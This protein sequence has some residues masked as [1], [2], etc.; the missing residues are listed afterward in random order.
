[1]FT[2]TAALPVA[3]MAIR[4]AKRP[5]DTKRTFGYHRFENPGGSLQRGALF[6]RRRVMTEAA[7]GL[8]ICRKTLWEKM[9]RHGVD[10]QQFGE[11]VEGSA[12]P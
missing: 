8:V 3:L 5:A 4:I 7:A 9:R 2:D 10:K 11:G 6:R 12:L 1:M